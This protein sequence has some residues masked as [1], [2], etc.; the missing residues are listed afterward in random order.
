ME[1]I[2]ILAVVALAALGFI[3]TLKD[4]LFWASLCGVMLVSVILIGIF[5]A[6]LP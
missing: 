2:H 1:L 4:K 5:G 6:S 3:F